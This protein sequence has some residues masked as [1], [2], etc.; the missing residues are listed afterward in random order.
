MK[1]ENIRKISPTS[2]HFILSLPLFSAPCPTG[3]WPGP[4]SP[5]P[6]ENLSP[7]VMAQP[8]TGKAAWEWLVSYGGELWLSHS[9][10]YG[11]YGK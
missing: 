6:S 4:R 3:H 10:N 7:K 11:N 9:S 8:G 1:S 5:V 2:D